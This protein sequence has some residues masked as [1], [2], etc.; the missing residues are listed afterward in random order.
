MTCNL[1]DMRRWKFNE[2]EADDQFSPFLGFGFRPEDTF[3]GK[4]WFSDYLLF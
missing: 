1:S 4:Q 3:N 2:V